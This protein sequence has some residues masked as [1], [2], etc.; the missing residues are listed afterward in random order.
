MRNY[1]IICIIIICILSILY[2]SDNLIENFKKNKNAIVVLTKGYITNEKYNMLINRNNLIYDKFY[3]LVD[4]NNYD[5]IIFHEGNITKEQQEYIQSKTPKVPLIFTYVKFYKK[6]VNNPICKNT[7]LSNRFPN[8]YKNMCYFWSISF[9]N[10]LEDY[11]YIIRID[12]D[13]FL[14]KI[15]PNIINNYI[16]SD[17]MFSSAYYDNNEFSDVIIGMDNLFNNYMKNNNLKPKNKLSMPYTNFM[18]L[19]INFFKNNK[20]VTNILNEIDLSDCIFSNR[21]GDL[22]IWGYILSYLIDKKYYILDT[23]ISYTH[24]SHSKKIN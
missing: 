10:Y 7:N 17:I 16:K 4:P 21:W 22:P 24:E 14:D 3:S 20:D 12:E 9:L 11:N 1:Q 2:K 8:G 15:D 23:G 18:I 19:N 13:C 5:V 6:E